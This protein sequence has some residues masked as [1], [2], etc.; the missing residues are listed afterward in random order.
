[1]KAITAALLA[2]STGVCATGALAELAK[3]PGNPPKVTPLP[4]PSGPLKADPRKIDP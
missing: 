4:T 2:A 3:Y 1:M